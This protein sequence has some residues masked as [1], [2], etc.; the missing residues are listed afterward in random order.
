VAPKVYI[1]K[2][3]LLATQVGYENFPGGAGGKNIFVDFGLYD[4]RQVNGVEYDSNFRLK[5]SNVNEYGTHAL[6]WLDYLEEP[7]KSVV[8]GLPA[9][10][11]EGKVSD[12]CK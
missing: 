11:G 7:A 9:G 1:K 2:G 12:Y 10:G 3:D 5:H 4:L 6:C 8:K